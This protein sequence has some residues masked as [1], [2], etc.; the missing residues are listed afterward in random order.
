MAH[1]LSIGFSAVGK[2]EGCTC[3]KCGQ[4]IKNIWTV[5]F[6]GDVTMNYGIDCFEKMYKT[7]KLTEYGVKLLKKAMKKIEHY[8]KQK[9]VWQKI[10]EEEAKEKGMLA[11]IDPESTLNQSRHGKSYWC[12]RTFEEYRE[13]MVNE[14]IEERFKEA[15][16]EIDKLKK[17]KFDI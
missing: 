13:F 10:T 9:E 16:E 5:K 17:A 3:D 7:G 14:W 4:Y 12:G 1:I 2:N 8:S 11:I 15:Q 6:D